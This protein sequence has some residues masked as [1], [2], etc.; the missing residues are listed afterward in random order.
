MTRRL[1]LLFTTAI[2]A[3]AA[4]AQ[5]EQ[6]NSSVLKKGD[7]L[8]N[9]TLSSSTYGNVNS[10]ELK[11][12][13]ILINIFAT[14]CGPCQKELKEVKEVLYPKYKDNPNFVMLVV[15]REHTDKELQAYNKKK[16]FEFALYPDPKREFTA[17]F[18]T[19]FIPRSYL[20]DKEGRVVFTSTGFKEEE[21]KEL[22]DL[23]DN[24]TK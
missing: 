2:F 3:V 10:E 8:P 21:F 18:A 1:I 23:I 7:F 6:E 14:W 12:K 20:I 4:F 11:G 19:K 5:S 17:K 15:G 9:F 24:L 22:M 16:G 13:V